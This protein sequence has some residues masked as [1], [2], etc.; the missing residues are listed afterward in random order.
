MARLNRR[1]FLRRTHHIPKREHGNPLFDLPL[2]TG[3]AF[4]GVASCSGR[5]DT[6]RKGTHGRRFVEGKGELLDRGT[7]TVCRS[8]LIASW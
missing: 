7:A 6:S 8:D 3:P 4:N 2:R 5:W 1:V